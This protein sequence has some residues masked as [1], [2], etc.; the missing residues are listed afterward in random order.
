MLRGHHCK[1]LRAPARSGLAGL[2]LA[3][4]AGCGSS[5]PFEL[6]PVSGKVTYGDGTLISAARIRLEF[7]PQVKPRDP[8]THPRPGSAEVNV[9][10]GTFSVAT[11]HKYGDGLVVGRHKVELF[12][13]DDQEV[14]TEL[15]VSPS[16]ITVGPESTEFYFKVD[17]P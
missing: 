16:E 4:A 2:L 5:E 12:R 7:T 9:A 1:G 13:Y 11:T 6:L 10:D 3:V 14:P 15:D 17:R 8:K